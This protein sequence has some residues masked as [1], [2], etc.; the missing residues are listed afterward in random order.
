[1]SVSFFYSQLISAINMYCTV[2]VFLVLNCSMIYYRHKNNGA[3]YRTNFYYH[4]FSWSIVYLVVLFQTNV[5]LMEILPEENLVLVILLTVMIICF[6][7]V[8]I[9]FN[10]FKILFHIY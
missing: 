3:K 10:V 7:I 6:R 5:P 9:K 1:M 4:W 8:I 2:V